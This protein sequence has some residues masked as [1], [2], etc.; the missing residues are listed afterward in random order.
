MQ[1]LDL[2]TDVL[3][4]D[5]EKEFPGVAFAIMRSANGA[6][7]WSVWVKMAETV[8][9][10]D[11]V[12]YRTYDFDAGKVEDLMMIHGRLAYTDHFRKLCNEIKSN[13]T[14]RT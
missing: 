5:L 4:R 6:G 7:M 14:G 9:P 11:G 8:K 12:L 2:D 10:P 13:G 1:D 3:L